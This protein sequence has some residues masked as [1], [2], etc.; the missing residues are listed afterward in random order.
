MAL[1][2]SCAVSLAQASVGDEE[3]AAARGK[4][5]FAA[6]CSR[7]HGPNMV[8]PG[9]VSYDL[10]K[11]PPTEKD[12]FRNA[13]LNGKGAM[14]GWQSSLSDEDIDALWMYVLTGGK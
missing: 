7:C 12:R 4:Q 5:L 11:F 10:R 8:N 14:P 6:T 9:T 1:L 2:L 13:V 3:S